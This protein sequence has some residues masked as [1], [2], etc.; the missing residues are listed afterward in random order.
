MISSAVCWRG[1]GGSIVSAPDA[2]LYPD[3]G[4]AAAPP[5]SDV[6]AQAIR[7][8]RITRHHRPTHPLSRRADL[9]PNAPPPTYVWEPGHWYWNGVRYHWQPGRYIAKPTTTATYTPGQW[10]QRPQGWRWVDGQWSYGAQRPG[11]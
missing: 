7:R 5:P 2:T 8:R 11:G 6:L 9:A 1:S 3:L 10:E 4:P